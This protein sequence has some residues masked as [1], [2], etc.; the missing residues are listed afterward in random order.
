M[1]SM[2][3][4]KCGKKP[5][6]RGRAGSPARSPAP[7]STASS[8]PAS[9]PS[10]NYIHLPRSLR[11]CSARSHWRLHPRRRPMTTRCC[12]CD[13]ARPRCRRGG[14]ARAVRR[15][16]QG[17]RHTWLLP[18]APCGSGQTCPPTGRPPCAS[19]SRPPAAQRASFMGATSRLRKLAPHQRAALLVAEFAAPGKVGEATTSTLGCHQPDPLFTSMARW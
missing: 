3:K 11:L 1:D 19:S 6:G 10:L 17:A 8:S 18:D 4:R 12:G 7:E 16:G 5:W 2:W 15:R 9:P 14:A 13:P